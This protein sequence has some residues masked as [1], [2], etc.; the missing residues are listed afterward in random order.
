[1]YCT[2]GAPDGQRTVYAD[3]D[4]VERA[5][6]RDPASERQEIER[7]EALERFGWVCLD[8]PGVAFP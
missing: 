3:A 2:V 8:P 5:L 4:T 6:I 7:R 1:M